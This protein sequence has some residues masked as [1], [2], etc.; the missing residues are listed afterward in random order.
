MN[1]LSIR[2]IRRED[3]AAIAAIIRTVMP[4]FGAKG[5][6]FAINDPEVDHMTA[7]YERPRA[8]YFVVEGSD[9]RVLGGGGVVL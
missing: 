7:G 1:D 3:D 2:P 9:G 5:P 8:A 6:G 4:E